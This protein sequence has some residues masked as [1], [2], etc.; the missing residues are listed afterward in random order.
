MEHQ[1]RLLLMT[2][3]TVRQMELVAALETTCG[4]QVWLAPTG[5]QAVAATQQHHPDLVLLDA[6]TPGLPLMEVCAS[7]AERSD[8]ML[9]QIWILTPPGLDEPLRELLACYADRL[10]PPTLSL[11]QICEEV[12]A[13]L[14]S[15]PPPLRWLGD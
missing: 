5:E 1:P 4:A 13:E 15:S 7:L 12:A 3:S 6:D 8:L 14:D 10:L 11:A 9:T 2:G